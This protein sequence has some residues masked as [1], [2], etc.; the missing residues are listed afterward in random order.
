MAYVVRR[1]RGRWEIRESFTTPDG[2]RARTLASFTT[3]TPTVIARAARAARTSLDP[4]ALLHAARRVG[5]PL[6]PK[7]ADALARS[8]L[9]TVA[10]GEEIRPGLRR[11]LRDRLTE[12]ED[13]THP[14]DESIAEWIGASPEERAAALIDLLGLVDRLPAPRHAPLRFPRMAQPRRG[15]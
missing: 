13:A 14:I 15:T 5:V 7:P 11:L 6:A 8:L 4:A 3:L 12:N 10:Q 2:P 9:R 1:P